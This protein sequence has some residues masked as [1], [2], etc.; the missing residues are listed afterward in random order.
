VKR[1]PGIRFGPI[2]F[3]Q[4]T[5][6]QYGE[7][8]SDVVRSGSITAW[9]EALGQDIRYAARGLCKAP[10]FTLV[11]VLTLAIGIGGT[12]T[13]FSALDALLL[14]PLPYPEQD[15]LV[16]LSNSYPRFPRARVPVSTTDVAHWRTDNQVFEQIEFVSGPDMVAMSGAGFAERVGVQHVSA[17]LFPLLGITSFL[18]SLPTDEVTEREGSL[19]VVLGYEFWQHHFAGD[20]KIIGRSIF[21][22][23]F[24]GPVIAVLKPGFNL[25][26]SGPPEAFL[27]D[28]MGNAAD[29][30]IGDS[31][32]LLGVGKRRPGV[33]LQQA[34]SAMNLTAQRLS[35][36]FPAA[37]RDMGVRVEPLQK[38]LFGRSEQV[39]YL[40]FA[41]V[42]FVL[43][44]AC[45][46]VAN[47]L[48]VR[49]DG[50]RKEIG[51]RV[52]LG[53]SRSS[54][55]RQLLSE[56]VLLSLTG[57]V[58]GLIL[59]LWGARILKVLSS[60]QFPTAGASLN[61]RVLFFT[62]GTCI[63]T[64]LLFGLIPAYRAS[65]HDLNECLREGGRSTATKSRHRT[66]NILVVAEIAVAL[67]SLICAGLMI[68]TLAH[69][70]RTSPG[71]DPSH[72]LTAEVRLTGEKYIGAN[73]PGNTGLTVIQTPVGI[74]CRQVLERLKNLPGV[75]GA[76][77]I[78][79]L[80]LAADAQHARPGFT[81]VGR[82]VDLSAGKPDVLL[83]AVSADYFRLMGIPILRGRG[84]TDHDTETSS[85][86]VVINEA[87]ARQFWPNEDP[88]GREVTFDFSPEERPRQIVGIVGNVKQLGLIRDS[89]PQAYVSYLQLPTH[90]AGWTESR[91]HKSFVVRT[92]STSAALIE[93]VRRVISELAP[94]SPVF[95]VRAVEQTVSNS[96][97]TWSV[98]SQLL[99]LFAAMALILA[100]IG[101]YGVMA[102][103]VS[104]RSHELGL[105]MALGAQRRHVVRLVLGQAMTLSFLG[106]MIGVAASFGVAPL[107]ARFLYGVKPQD[108]LTLVLVS[109]L[110]IAVTLFASYIPARNATAIDPMETL[111]HE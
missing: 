62:L 24:S 43:L 9:I 74:F 56:S 72:L 46:N 77:L 47:L 1:E 90:V 68:N 92:Q 89:P 84:V 36:A 23:T 100:A 50:R 14:R 33:S 21:V 26:G 86:V 58:G 25:F 20:P 2:S 103:S 15:R 40:L 3:L 60:R 76:A 105:R 94:D 18:G 64:G 28:G 91:L 39:L 30:G 31:R 70:L 96:A 111:R 4:P 80:P 101:I 7:L 65:K 69:I 78:D 61:A 66:R 10:A 67:V 55:I 8:H 53:A 5:L 59:S 51:V 87:M 110:L 49:G 82:S 35:Q 102:Y 12:T 106:V 95:G 19:G 85:S 54:L 71:F 107:L 34:Q 93:N 98:L 11:A 52:A 57:G 22:D 83:D 104:E 79:W 44:I 13:I 75:E 108:V 38:G 45:T 42:G 6:S 29:S 32:W 63:L 73:D 41:A 16:A 109:S 17:R 97:R 27:I 99:G 88:V 37:Y 81:I 48:L